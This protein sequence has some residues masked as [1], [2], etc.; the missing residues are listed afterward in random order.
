MKLSKLYSNQTHL[1]SP[2]KFN[3]R[4]NVV[5]GQIRHPENYKKDTHNLGKTTLA[6]LLD[7]MFLAGRD[8]RQFLFKNYETF[9]SFTF[10][11]EIEYQANK[12]LTI[13]RSVDNHSKISFKLH[14]QK[15][16][17][18]SKLSDNEWNHD[19]VAIDQAK[20]LL[21][22][23]LNFN[24]LKDWDY[25]KILGYL[26]RTQD[27]FNNV[28]KLQKFQGSDADWKPYMADLLSF[29][30]DLAKENYE[31]QSKINSL[32]EKIKNLPRSNNNLNEELSNIDGKILIRNIELKKLENFVDNFNFNPIDQET[33]EVLVDELDQRISSL[34][35]TEY[36]IKNNISRIQESLNNDPIKFDTTK[37]Q[38][39]FEEA[40]ILFPKEITKDFEQLIEFNKKI[41]KERNQYLKEELA[42]LSEDLKT[43]QQKLSSLNTTRSEQIQFLRETEIVKKY[44]ISNG[45]IAQ[46][47]GDIEYLHKSKDDLEKILNLQKEKTDLKKLHDSIEI[48]MQENVLH[49]NQSTDSLFSQIRIYF[50]EII[51]KV[52]DREGSLNVYLNGEG[53][54]E[55]NATYRDKS[56]ADTSEGDGHSYKKL[57][58]FAFDLAVSR[59]Y[60]N[61]NY[62]KFLYID[63][64]F[65]NFDIRKKQNALNVLREYCGY[66]IQIIITT[67]ESEISELSLDD[68]PI[69]SD[70]EIILTLH[71]DGEDG[72]LFKIPTW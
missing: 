9:K 41:T 56:G 43:T 64:V 19:K 60:S 55:F 33:I 3:D 46:I 25:R 22:G 12:F 13:K 35:M 24:A 48:K 2:I 30:G 40:S 5:L 27:D 21:D 36:T 67:I 18:F 70:N 66:G 47:K 39:L 8:K 68:K 29:R 45:Q 63:G 6:K 26:V 49:V 16:D 61:K 42:D 14:D 23:W 31:I 37:V 44:K 38:N 28:F 72:R 7:F 58:C 71:D 15:F 57:L 69:F 32:N 20:L 62:P 10:Y 53:N 59:T 4:F 1:F 11:L 65:D 52:L 34:N 54:L 50:N 17:D 51:N